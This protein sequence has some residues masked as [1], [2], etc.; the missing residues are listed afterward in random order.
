MKKNLNIAYLNGAEGMIR[1]GA[2]GGSGESGGGSNSGGNG[3]GNQIVYYNVDTDNKL[4][5]FSNRIKTRDNASNDIWITSTAQWVHGWAGNSSTSS[6]TND[7]IIAIE[8]QYPIKD[9]L[10]GE[11]PIIFNNLEEAVDY[12]ELNI[13]DFTPI[14][15]EQFYSLE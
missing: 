2:S 6:P 12:F 3:E 15:K 14:T 1:R 13:L 5:Y 7:S 10:T 4:V 11:D 9:Y 8:V